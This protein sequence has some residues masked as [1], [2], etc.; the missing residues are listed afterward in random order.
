MPMR[1]DKA[2]AECLSGLS[3]HFTISCVDTVEAR[4]E[5]AAILK[6]MFKQHAYN[7]DRACYWMDFG[8]SRYTGQVLLATVRNIEQPATKK[9]TAVGSL[10]LPVDE[11]KE[12]FEAAKEDTTPSCSLAE[13]LTRQVYQ[14]I[15]CPNG[16]VPFMA[17][18]PRGH[19]NKPR[20]FPEFEEF[21]VA[22]TANLV[23][24]RIN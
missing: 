16:R 18:V 20:I 15:A 17:D 23:S 1:F 22:A 6:Q 8:N 21:P 19:G 4:F 3:A 10:P 14:F 7:R 5:L 24:C 2:N 9:F 12:L 13:A 11:F